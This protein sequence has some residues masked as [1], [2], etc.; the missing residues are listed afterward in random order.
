MAY[1]EEGEKAYMTWNLKRWVMV[2][3]CWV[4]TFFA[5]HGWDTPPWDRLLRMNKSDFMYR[6]EPHMIA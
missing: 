5:S 2:E 1:L 6:V 3:R 4:G